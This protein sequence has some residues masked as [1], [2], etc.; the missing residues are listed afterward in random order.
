[1]A[2]ILDKY[3]VHRMLAMRLPNLLE[4]LR[5]SRSTCAGKLL[6]PGKRAVSG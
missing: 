5:M 1:M 6:L 3:Y 2:V 4:R